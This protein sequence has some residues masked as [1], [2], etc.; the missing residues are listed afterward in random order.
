LADGHAASP[1]WSK[2]S[3][4]STN[5]LLETGIFQHDQPLGRIDLPPHDGAAPVIASRAE[6]KKFDDRTIE[7]GKHDVSSMTCFWAQVRPLDQATRL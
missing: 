4:I 6:F 1:L 2:N 7:N 5:E 3:Q